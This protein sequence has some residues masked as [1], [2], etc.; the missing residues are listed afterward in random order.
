MKNLISSVTDH[1][2]GEPV[3]FKAECDEHYTQS[4]FIKLAIPVSGRELR[5][6]LSFAQ[7]RMWFLEQLGA[8]RALYQIRWFRRIHGQLNLAALQQSLSEIIRRHEILRTNFAVIEM[9]ATSDGRPRQIIHQ[10][11]AAELPVIDL[12]AVAESDRAGAAE[13]LVREEARRGFELSHG[14]LFRTSLIKLAAEDH[15][16]LI[17]MHHIISDGWSVGVLYKELSLLYQAYCAGGESPLPD[18]PIQ[19][20]DYALWQRESLQGAV[21]E[22][23]LGYWRQQLAGAPAL[24][25]LP[26]DRARPAM[27]TFRGGVQR[28]QLS[29]QLS[30][31]LSELVRREGVT[32]FMTLLAAFQV[33][34]YRY[35]GQEDIVVGTP[36]AGRNRAEL[37]PLIGFFVN[38]LALRTQVS[39]ELTFTELVERVKRVCLGA[40]AHQ[41]IPFEKLVEEL[42]PERD[43]SH[44]PLFQVMMVLQNTPAAVMRLGELE[45][46]EFEVE[47]GTA[48]FD[49][50]LTVREEEG[51]GL[52]VSLE[53]STDLFDAETV[54]QMARHYERLLESIVEQPQARLS[55]LELLTADEQRRLLVEWNDT[56]VKYPEQSCLHQLFEEQVARTPEAVALVFDEE[57]LSYRE[58]N[59]RANQV[60]HYLMKRGVGAESLV[61]I[62]VERSLEM[63]VGLL[64]ILK[65]GGAYV[66]LDPAYPRERIAFTLEDAGAA[67]LLT[68]ARLLEILSGHQA[69]AVCLDADWPEIARESAANPERRAGADNLAYVIYTSGSTGRPKG[70]PIQHHSAVAF[71]HWSLQTFTRAELSGV[72]ASTSICFDL[73]VFELFVTL[74]A[75][76]KIVLALNALQLPSLPATAGVTLVNTVPSAIAELVRVEGIPATVRT[77]NLAGEPLQNALVQH[78]YRQ[79]TIERVLNLYGP[80]EDTTYSTWT[81]VEKGASRQVTIGRPIA[82]TQVYL[83]DADLKAVPVGVTGELYISGDGLAR[84]YLNRAELTAERFVP[85]PFSE[86]AGARMYRT[87]DLARYRRDGEIEFL[88]RIDH[89]V[90]VRGF[91]I[92]LG[93][94]EAALGAHE[95]VSD[96]VVTAR[97]ERLGEKLLVAYVVMVAAEDAPSVGELR[98]YLKERL[99]E[100]ML[101]SVFVRLGELPLTPNGKVDRRALPVPE[102]ARPELGANFVAP[103]EGLESELVQIWEELLGVHP[104]G[105]QDNFFDLGGHS[106]LGVRLF[107]HIENRFGQNLPLA[108]L[109]HSPTIEQLVSVL[110]EQGRPELWSSLVP[111]RPN[112]S[113]PPLFCIHAG[114]AN[115]LI[116]RPLARRLSSDQPVYALQAQGLDG[117]KAP[118]TRVEDMAAHYMREV[119]TVQP[120]GPYYLLG[121][122]FGG[123]VAFE[124]AQRFIA[125]GESVALLS[126]FDTYCP[127]HPLSQRIR[128]HIGHLIHHG[129]KF[130]ARNGVASI[131]RKIKR[132]FSKLTGH[133]E[134]V[135]PSHSGAE[136][137]H[138]NDPLARTQEAIAQAARDYAPA[139]KIY[140]GKI[141]FFY[142][143]DRGAVKPFEDN[144]LLW[145]KMAAGGFEVHVIPG[146]HTTIREEPHVA[147]LAEKLTACLKQAQEA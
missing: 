48:K 100:Y 141:I 90:K 89:Q 64:G 59:E 66:P 65:A 8:D 19:Y 101:P 111:I 97:E 99:P 58:L 95:R 94:I 56:A 127:L 51:Q 21:L 81:V 143:E 135:T 88:G 84:G 103:K 77:V 69:Q 117:K 20:R 126:L 5:L 24:L 98:R 140:P 36:V 31:R 129:P 49:L 121:A 13:R 109:F 110:R 105:V 33:L 106:L 115:V 139:N 53:Y 32:L 124:M 52:R 138:D 50:T 87:G 92:E 80:S 18:L 93:E 43:L 130:Y 79:P 35:S 9:E 10:R 107:A 122:S 57:Q 60:A 146:D 91:R 46:Q 125:G 1:F 23:Q 30:G 118:Y 120:A 25:E 113:R 119:R 102:D 6:E 73:S 37:E 133:I 39:G 61:G 12:S 27:Q 40:Y 26:T 47:S 4:S 85:N 3:H 68:Q 144:R 67:L 145:R 76:G 123:L 74:S 2:S 136:K 28:R 45:L 29:P 75:G 11:A 7:E 112:G 128:C 82:N 96:C 15:L 63:V 71:I 16:F 86:S 72:L 22:Q 132:R 147:I 34:L 137:Q 134:Q 41:D 114:G 142:A 78:I 62:C 14:S 70:V 38:T 17:N 83:L 116:Y 131:K 44:T 104:I 42:Q 108:T 55:E 54:E